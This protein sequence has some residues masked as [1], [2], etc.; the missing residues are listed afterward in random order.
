MWLSRRMTF[1]LRWMAE[2]RVQ[3]SVDIKALFELLEWLNLGLLST[4][5]FTLE[6]MTAVLL[7]FFCP[8]VKYPMG[9][10]IP[11]VGMHGAARLPHTSRL[12]LYSGPPCPCLSRSLHF[13]P[14]TAWSGALQIPDQTPFC[15]VNRKS[16]LSKVGSP[17]SRIDKT[18]FSNEKEISKLDFSDFNTRY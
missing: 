14:P 17:S 7:R 6:Q 1:T 4:H 10:G 15:Q 8:C 18:S 13:Q 2:C 12:Q 11:A 16:W 5:F 3:V 9:L